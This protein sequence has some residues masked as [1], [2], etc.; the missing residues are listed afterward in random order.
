[1]EKQTEAIP[2]LWVRVRGLAVFIMYEFLDL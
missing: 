1:M 2:C